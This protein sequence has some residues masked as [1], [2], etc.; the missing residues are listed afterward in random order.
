M[1]ISSCAVSRGQARLLSIQSLLAIY[2]V[3]YC[4]VPVPHSDWLVISIEAL[5]LVN[6]LISGNQNTRTA[7]IPKVTGDGGYCLKSDENMAFFVNLKTK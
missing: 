2:E 7:L 4:F 5:L 6:K 3:I 1:I